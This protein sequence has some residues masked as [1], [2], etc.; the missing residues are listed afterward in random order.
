MLRGG[1]RYNGYLDKVLCFP[2]QAD[3]GDDRGMCVGNNYCIYAEGAV[4]HG[5]QDFGV[6]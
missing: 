4:V 6:R 1:A 3:G 5:V 2:R